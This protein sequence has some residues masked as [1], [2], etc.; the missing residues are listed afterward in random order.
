MHKQAQF[1][2]NMQ[3][4]AKDHNNLQDFVQQT[5]DY[6]VA[7]AISDGQA[8]AGFLAAK[9]GT[10]EVT[11]EP[12][13]MYK[14]GVIY[15]RE[16]AA[17]IDVLS[18]LPVS[19]QKYLAIVVSGAEVDSEDEP[20]KFLIDATERTTQV[21]TVSTVRHRA[22]TVSTVAGAESASPQKPTV[23]SDL[24]TIGWALLDTG[25]VVSVEM[26]P[27]EELDSVLSNAGRLGVLEAWRQQIGQRIDT[28]ATDITKLNESVRERADQEAIFDLAADVAR[29]KEL[30]ELPDTYADYGA[31]RF[32]DD[33]ESDTQNVNYLARIEEGVRF[34][35][36]AEDVSALALFNPIDPLV[37][38]SNGF[39][40]P[41]YTD[42]LRLGVENKIGE[43]SISQYASQDVDIV[44]R[45]R[46]RRRIRYGENRTVCTNSRWWR[47]GRYDPAQGTFH[48]EGDTWEVMNGVPDTHGGRVHWVRLRRFWVDTY[49]ETYWDRIVTTTTVTGSVIGQTWLNSQDMWLSTIELPLTQVGPSGNL[50]V[51]ICYAKDGKPD[52]GNAIARVTVD[53]ADLKA[54]PE[55]T[56]VPMPAVFLEAGR[57]YAMVLITQGAH[58]VGIASGAD[59]AQGTLFYST[60]GAFFQG[61]LTQDL[62]FRLYAAQFDQ[63][64][65]EVK[66]DALSLSG[67]ITDID[68]LAPMTVPEG[69]EVRFEVLPSGGSWTPLDEVVS[70]NSVL[71]NLPALLEFR[72]V[73]LGTTDVMPGIDLVNSEVR[74]SRPRTTFTHISTPILPGSPTQTVKVT[75]QLAD[76]YEANHDLD[77][78][79]DDVTNAVNGIAPATVV[80]EDLGEVDDANHRR[81]RRTFE[82]TSAELPAATSEFKIQLDGTTTSALD[83]FIVEERV[84]LTF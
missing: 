67:G 49:E 25:G 31:D 46:T 51:L 36:E 75:V 6:L 19:T 37:T 10:S 57:R 22:A 52:V 48:K 53:H 45:T 24:V 20:R 17:V 32:L 59:F 5:F 61:D 8:Y 9:T 18:Q 28:L 73:F 4:V 21:S 44:Q 47:S 77:C 39:L 84:H 27:A 72:A 79:I 33:E 43:L 1:Y 40:L 42:V 16:T 80:D 41:K 7:D 60:D 76:Y 81:I 3:G 66:L 64:R 83:T 50:E 29:L 63:P 68:I 62:M 69:T 12:G 2:Q 34:G 58:Y 26:N 35:N 74:I 38:V 11:V 15:T 56:S 55:W 65:I 14:A 54:Y 23:S 70:G 13:R 30:N 78:V 71:Y 82:W